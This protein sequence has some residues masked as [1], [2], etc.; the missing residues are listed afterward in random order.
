MKELFM[1]MVAGIYVTR[2]Y[3]TIQDGR[4]LRFNAECCDCAEVDKWAH[5]N[6]VTPHTEGIK[7]VA[8]SGRYKVS[9][10]TGS[11]RSEDLKRLYHN[12]CMEHL[13]EMSTAWHANPIK[14]GY[15]IISSD[16]MT[17]STFI[18]CAGNFWTF[19]KGISNIQMNGFC[20]E[21]VEECGEKW[22]HVSYY[23][24]GVRYAWCNKIA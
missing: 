5:I 6:G 15:W 2:V 20:R 1:R 14:F 11:N 10:Y 9:A 3:A 21:Y 13:E 24:N 23:C 8:E 22:V 19:M 4:G 12:R 7:Y 18:Q 17:E 16:G